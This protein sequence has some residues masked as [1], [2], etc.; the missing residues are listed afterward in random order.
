MYDVIIIGAGAAGIT[1]AIYAARANLKF[2]IISK[3]VG[4]LTLWSSDIENYTGYHNLTGIDLVEKF[5]EHM[6]DYDIS[7]KEDSVKKIEKKNGNFIV[8]TDK[9]EL[10]T[11]TVVVCSGSSPRKLKVPGGEE[12]E[13]NSSNSQFNL[14]KNKSSASRK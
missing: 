13:G 6:K 8:K 14:E 12:Y 9:E 5:K 10:E 2:E 7:I 3:D 4:G 1:A 11:K